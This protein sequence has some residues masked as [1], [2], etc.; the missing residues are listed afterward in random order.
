MIP[1]IYNTKVTV[2]RRTSAFGSSPASRDVLNNPVYGTPTTS[3][4]TIYSNMPARLAFNAKPIIF[5]STA[6][7]V[8]PNGV[9]YIPPDYSIY[10]E[11]RIIT[12]DGVEYVVVSVVAG[13]I[14]NITLDHF[15]LELALP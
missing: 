2:K 4:Q 3:W 5:A 11:D 15:E 6:E 7:R 10:H 8:T 1:A 14:N 9:A 12:S 13:Y